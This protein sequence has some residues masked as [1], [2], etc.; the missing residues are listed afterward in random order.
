MPSTDFE[1]CESTLQTGNTVTRRLAYMS[2][3]A[4][5]GGLSSY[6]TDL[7]ILRIIL[8]KPATLKKLDSQ[9]KWY[10][11]IVFVDGQKFDPSAVGGKIIK[12]ILKAVFTPFPGEGQSIGEEETLSLLLAEKNKPLDDSLD[13]YGYRL[14]S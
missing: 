6:T 7:W 13:S 12:S 4:L 3:K 9:R 11:G 2:S 1:F 8:Y 10:V 14:A 5:I